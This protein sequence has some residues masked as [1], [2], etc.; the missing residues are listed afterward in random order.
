[1]RIVWLVM[2]RDSKLLG[3]ARLGPPVERL[4]E[5]YQR[6]SCFV[7]F[8]SGTLPPKK[9]GKRAGLEDPA[10]VVPMTSA[11]PRKL[12]AFCFARVRKNGLGKKQ[13]QGVCV[14]VCSGPSPKDSSPNRSSDCELSRGPWV[15]KAESLLPNE[16]GH[17]LRIC[18]VQ[19]QF[20]GAMT[21]SG[22]VRSM[23]EPNQVI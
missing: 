16:A 10:D 8:S 11:D 5:G 22:V 13:M 9:G 6:A 15:A 1:M 18:K 4:E 17:V 19:V 12:L 3:F 14:A 21:E 2:E 20:V 23:G 7:D